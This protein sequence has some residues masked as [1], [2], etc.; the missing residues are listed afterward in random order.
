[1]S[2]RTTPSSD[3]FRDDLDYEQLSFDNAQGRELAR[4]QRRRAGGQQRSLSERLA[5]HEAPLLVDVGRS[6][7]A[8]QSPVPSPD[9]L[10]RA[11]ETS[12]MLTVPA[13]VGVAPNITSPSSGVPSVST[14]RTAAQTLPSP[15]FSP[16]Q[17]A[18]ME[19]ILR[20]EVPDTQID[21]T[22]DAVGLDNNQLTDY[23]VQRPMTPPP[24]RTPT[25]PPSPPPPPPLS[26]RGRGRPPRRG[27]GRGRGGAPPG[28]DG[29]GD[30]SPPGGGGGGGGDGRR[31]CGRGHGTPP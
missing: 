4:V 5:E 26:P 12:G 17:I 13:G 3:E 14:I 2:R 27:R 20:G 18:V 8:S 6:R 30:G 24:A 31:G 29:D 16:R 19:R 1:M 22:L 15:P 25:P 23:M 10:Q 7:C 28:G 9:L 21:A 11:M